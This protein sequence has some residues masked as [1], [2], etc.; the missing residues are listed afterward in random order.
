[1][2]KFLI[3]V[4]MPLIPGA[5]LITICFSLNDIPG[6]SVILTIQFIYTLALL[7]T[8]IIYF[9]GREK[10]IG[11]GLLISFLINFVITGIMSLGM[12]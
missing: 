6:Y 5:I 10:A 2:K 12:M 4:F 7:T 1:M 11:A 8:S 3:A 9:T